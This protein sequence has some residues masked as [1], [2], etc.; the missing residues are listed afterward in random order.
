MKQYCLIATLFTLFFAFDISSVF[1]SHVL[2]GEITYSYIGNDSFIV[3]NRMLRDC[4]GIPYSAN[5]IT[6]TPSGGT[7]YTVNTSASTQ[8]D[9]TPIAK[10][11]QSRC[12]NQSSTFPIGVSIVTMTCKFKA[13][14]ACDYTLSQSICCLTGAI[15]TGVGANNFYIESQLNKC[16]TGD[17]SSPVFEFNPVTITCLNKCSSLFQNT[18]SSD[19]GDSLIYSL[20][21]PLSASG[22]P[23]SYN[24]P[25]SVTEPLTYNGA[26]GSPLQTWDYTYCK[27]FHYDSLTGELNFKPT[28]QE[29]TAMCFKVDQW[30]KNSSGVYK[31]IGSV[32]RQTTVYVMDCGTNTPPFI[33]GIDSTSSS[34]LAA[35]GSKISLKL[36]GTDADSK[37][38]LKL[39]WDN[40]IPSATFTVNSNPKPTATFSWT[41]K[42]TDVRKKPYTFIATVVDNHSP[43]PGVFQRMYYVYVHDSFP[44][45]TYS[46]IYNNCNKYTFT[47]N[48]DTTLKTSYSWK[49]DATANVSLK[50]ILTFIFTKSGKHYIDLT[51]TSAGGC[52]KH[53]YDTLYT[54]TIYR[55]KASF[56]VLAG[57][58]KM[59]LTIT[60]NSQ[61]AK[62]HSMTWNWKFDDATSA[63]GANPVKAFASSGNHTIWLI[64]KS[65]SGCL[66]SISKTALINPAPK[67]I[68]TAI[69][70]CPKTPI[71][72]SNSSSIT[73]G[74]IASYKWDFGDGTASTVKSPVKS[75]ATSNIFAVKLV[76]I[77][78]MGCKD[79]VSQNITVYP[80]PNISFT[81][82]NACLSDTVKFVNSSTIVSGS[83]LAYLWNLGDLSYAT[84]K[85]VAHKY[86]KSGAYSVKL[87]ATSNSGCMDTLVKAVTVFTSPHAG[88][89]QFVASCAGIPIQFYDS[90]SIKTPDSIGGWNW[91]FG[92]KTTQSVRNP[93][94]GYNLGGTYSVRLK[95]TA[96]N[97]CTDSIVKTASIKNGPNSGFSFSK[98]GHR[99]YS[100]SA[101]DATQSR[102]QWD[103]GDKSPGF[104]TSPS[105]TFN[106]DGIYHVY[107]KVTSANGC[108]DSTEQD[109]TVNT[110]GIVDLTAEDLHLQLSPNP[111]NRELNLKYTLQTKA[112]VKILVYDITGKAIN[113]VADEMQTPG[114]HKYILDAGTYFPASGIY[115]FQLIIDGH[116]IT[117]QVVRA[118]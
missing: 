78:D 93:T 77:S 65:D 111:F 4:N 22:S 101:S 70:N 117:G 63:T 43:V 6:I 68:Y 14:T 91:N 97:G 24:S 42:S 80:L 108:L 87:V 39:G 116:V 114:D 67:A 48:T 23:I 13:G 85:N 105:H 19:A 38:T 74:T 56:S 7:A 36:Y 15:T 82:A 92:D 96:T 44:K 104:G 118:Y 109:V 3:T 28:K 11:V 12:A 100:F 88:M 47:A 55:V 90:S 73:S 113:P 40:S 79:S 99:Q 103:F 49:I 60:D 61:P 34:V 102:Y 54:D 46:K 71:N 107:L 94:H 5:P 41:P 84:T 53:F 66:D 86:S 75:Y 83:I 89:K 51:V 59:P 69:N 81:V 33:T 21:S 45:V 2:G 50:R 95:V 37:D 29:V 52:Q 32:T 35:C 112:R 72:F 57:C 16:E 8:I 26:F 62:G 18:N 106:A 20:V 98:T 27:G 31:K 64:T 58:P 9:I 115:S 1:A 30:H 110:T 17:H 25:Y 10:N 76:A